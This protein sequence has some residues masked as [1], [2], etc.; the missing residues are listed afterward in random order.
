MTE[1]GYDCIWLPLFDTTSAGEYGLLIPSYLGL[2]HHASTSLICCSYSASSAAPAFSDSGSS[3]NESEGRAADTG[4]SKGFKEDI[5]CADIEKFR[6]SWQAVDLATTR[7][8]TVEATL[9]SIVK[10]VADGGR[11]AKERIGRTVK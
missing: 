7:R 5:R 10:L 1:L 3:W 9:R 2:A 8:G 4:C 6:T 11:E